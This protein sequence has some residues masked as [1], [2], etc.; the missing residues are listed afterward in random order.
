MA[1]KRIFLTEKQIEAIKEQLASHENKQKRVFFTENQILDIKQKIQQARDETNIN[2][3][4]GQKEAGNYKM[5]R[6]NV[7][8]FN[9]AIENP[10][11]S[12][13]KGKDRTGKEWKTLMHNDYGYF[14]HTLAIDGDAVD[15]FLGDDLN[16]KTIFAI[17]Q[18]IN[19]KF[20]ETKVMLGFKS[21]ED[22]KKAYLSNYEKDWKGFWKITEVDID[23]FK[24]WLYD[25]YKQRKP[26]SEYTEIKKHKLNESLLKESNFEDYYEEMSAYDTINKFVEDMN[27]GRQTQNW[28]PLINPSMYQKALQIFT[29]QGN[30]DGFPERYIYQWIG[31]IMRNTIQLEINSE[32]AGHSMSCPLDDLSD[33]HMNEYIKQKLGFTVLDWGSDVTL[34]ITPQ[35]L[36]SFLQ[37]EHLSPAEKEYVDTYLENNNINEEAIHQTGDN[38]GQMVMFLSQPELDYY[39]SEKALRTKINNI[40]GLIDIFNE[41]NKEHENRANFGVSDDVLSVNEQ[42]QLLL[43]MDLSRL[44]DMIGFYDWMQ[45]PDGSDAWSDYGL[46][47]LFEILQEYNDNKSTPEQTLVLIN[48]ALDVSHPRGDMASIFIEGGSRTLTQISN[49]GYVNENAVNNAGY[50]KLYHSTT[51]KNLA[52]ILNGG[53]MRIDMPHKEGHGDELWFSVK[54]NDYGNEIEISIQVPQQEF[55]NNYTDFQF[56]NT[57]HV[58]VARNLELTKYHPSIEQ[59]AL[60]LPGYIVYFKKDRIQR[61]IDNMPNGALEETVFAECDKLREQNPYFNTILNFI[62][63]NPT[64]LS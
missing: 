46:R 39:D 52:N 56:V 30:L 48:R 43:Q 27:N 47:P 51:Y 53:V 10:K 44:L 8:G 2:P 38:K 59:F 33:S 20:D 13:R 35:Y 26:F 6:V 32:L 21:S 19:G 55:G 29:K 60:S 17:D 34:E 15:V 14:T 18:K 45:M 5:G 64:L 28:A 50:T 1:K 16:C 3:T 25:G 41:H 36:I 22:A 37:H 4:E 63:N 24:K 11:G 42:G 54:P 23:V 40:Q 62:E 49:T 7:L 9:I 12:Y 58:V 57:N 61:Y 31:I